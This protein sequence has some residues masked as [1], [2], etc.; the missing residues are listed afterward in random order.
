M[1]TIRKAADG[2]G[3]YAGL[4]Q[5]TP[6]N[7]GFST[8][9]VRYS[10]FIPLAD[11]TWKPY[12]ALYEEVTYIN[13]QISEYTAILAVLGLSNDFDDTSN[14]VT[15]R[16]IGADHATYTS[17]NA[18]VVHRKGVDTDFTNNVY[19]RAVFLFTKLEV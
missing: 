19:A 4:A 2:H 5:I 18:T 15:Y 7:T 10:E 14:E 6:L 3:N 11:G 1:T 16:T 13:L 9:G 8:S 17:Y 12:G